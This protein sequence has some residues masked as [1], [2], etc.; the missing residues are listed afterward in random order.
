MATMRSKISIPPDVLF[1]D[2]DGE[3]VILNMDT[4]EYYGLDEVGT[5]MW[6]L[7]AQLGQIELARQELLKEY[8]VEESRLEQDL[9]DFVGKLE[10]KELLKTDDT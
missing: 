9:L 4:G 7:L 5:R 6:T 2:V 3:A 1:R 10:A 8:D